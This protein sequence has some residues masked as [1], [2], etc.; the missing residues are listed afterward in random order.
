MHNNLIN[1]DGLKTMWQVFCFG[2]HYCPSVLTRIFQ[3]KKEV[4]DSLLTLIPPLVF[5]P[6]HG[7]NNLLEQLE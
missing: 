6:G 2:L 4:L 3:S 1:Q 5:L 7:K